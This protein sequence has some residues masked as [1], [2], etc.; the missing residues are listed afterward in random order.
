MK[1]NRRLIIILWLLLPPQLLAAAPG[2]DYRTALPGIS[3]ES[4]RLGE[5]VPYC[6]AGYGTQQMAFRVDGRSVHSDKLSNPYLP[7]FDPTSSSF[8]R[9]GCKNDLLFV[10]YAGVDGSLRFNKEIIL[11]GSKYN[12]IR[13]QY[14]VITAGHAFSLLPHRLYLDLGLGYSVLD[15][16]LG[17]YGSSYSSQTT[18]KTTSDDGFMFRAGF[19]LII[20]H[21]VMLNWQ[22]EKSIG[23][24]SVLD[25]TGQLGLNFISRF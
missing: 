7:A 6:Y 16:R 8:L 1:C 17:R 18:G 21:Y 10:D 9:F 15:Y 23:S 22:H 24:D 20:T 3:R 5:G 19:S 11:N 14:R 2:P 12:T 4:V 13:Y 25:Y